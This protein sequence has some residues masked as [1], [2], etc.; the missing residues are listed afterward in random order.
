[1]RALRSQTP[2]ETVSPCFFVSRNAPAIASPQ[3]IAAQTSIKSKAWRNLPL[4]E[5]GE[6][7]KNNNNDVV[8]PM[9][10]CLRKIMRSFIKV[11]IG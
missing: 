8:T 9:V 10:V 6:T 5:K 2:R 11:P 3:A 7:G 4:F 1:M